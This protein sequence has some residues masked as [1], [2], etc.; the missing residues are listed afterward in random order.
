MK[1]TIAMLTASM[2]TAILAHPFDTR[3]QQC[4]IAP[5]ATPSTKIQPLSTPTASTAQACQKL[6]TEHSSCKS[7][8]FG[9]PADAKAP[10]CKL[11]SVPAA[12]VPNQGNNLY[13]FDKACSDKAVPNT[14]PT[15]DKPRGEVKVRV[16]RDVKPEGKPPVKD[17]PHADP[18]HNKR[19]NK[20]EGKPPVE[21][22]PPAGDKPPKGKAPV[23]PPNNKRGIK[24]E[25]KP[26]VGDKPKAPLPTK[27]KNSGNNGHKNN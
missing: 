10:T 8:L 13:V 25:D 11:Y 19:D 26:R 3:S 16:E 27:D 15:Q 20:P 9:L 18:P 1:T 14:K 12:Q 24:P 23:N 21:D 4:N 6:C 5:S 17:E 2:A 22:Q 7:F